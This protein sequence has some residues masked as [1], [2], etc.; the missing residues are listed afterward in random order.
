MTNAVKNLPT[1]P[2][3]ASLRVLVVRHFEPSRDAPSEQ[4]M[5]TQAIQRSE[6]LT[7]IEPTIH[8]EGG[9]PGSGGWQ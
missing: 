6:N 7:V 8:G 5:A 4:E 3:A 1:I 9:G 2:H